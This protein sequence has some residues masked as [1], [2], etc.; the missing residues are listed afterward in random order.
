MTDLAETYTVGHTVPR[1]SHTTV[2][3]RVHEEI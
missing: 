2:D 1:R 3:V